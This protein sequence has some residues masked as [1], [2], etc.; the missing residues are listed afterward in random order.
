MSASCARASAG[1]PP[2]PVARL[3][4]VVVLAT[5]SR[6]K[7]LSS[8]LLSSA[9]RLS[10]S[11]VK[12]T[13]RPSAESPGPPELPSAPAPA[14]P[15]A[16]VTRTVVFAAASRTKMLVTPLSSS[17]ERVSATLSNAT[18]SPLAVIAGE[19]A[20][21]STGAPAGPVAREIRTTSSL[22]ASAGEA[23]AAGADGG[24]GER[25][26]PC[27]PAWVAHRTVRPTGTSKGGSG[28]PG[29]RRP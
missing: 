5:R 27:S 12:T 18:R 25:D 16:R 23:R 19:N 4:S 1:A 15:V 28:A 24:Q 3:T 29:A 7:T 2:A 26:E 21:A 8:A 20:L 13:S 22:A 14:A 11:E 17:A 10:A 6:T 9:D